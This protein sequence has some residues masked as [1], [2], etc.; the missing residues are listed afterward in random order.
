V[1]VES[2]LKCIEDV[3]RA[4]ILDAGTD[5]LDF[6]EISKQVLAD[7]EALHKSGG[8]DAL[9][10]RELVEAVA[11]INDT[12]F[13]NGYLDIVQE[14]KFSKAF[15]DKI[16][17]LPPMEK[18][19]RL[20]Q[21][22]RNVA[23][24]TEKV[25]AADIRI[26]ALRETAEEKAFAKLGMAFDKA[27]SKIGVGGL[28]NNAEFG[29]LALRAML[30]GT[31]DASSKLAP[32][33]EIVGATARGLN[34]DAI[35]A[36]KQA[37][38]P[39]RFLKGY[40]QRKYSVGALEA[41]KDRAVSL[42]A[43]KL[44]PVRHTPGI[45][46]TMQQVAERAYRSIL[47]G[48][49]STDTISGNKSFV[50]QRKVHFKDPD[51]EVDFFLEFGEKPPMEILMD[52]V[53]SSAV[54]SATQVRY[55][56]RWAQLMRKQTEGAVAEAEA[57]FRAGTLLSGEKNKVVAMGKR[58][59]ADIDFNLGALNKFDNPTVENFTN[60]LM[61]YQSARLLGTVIKYTTF[62][63]HIS[64]VQRMAE[65]GSLNIV[66]GYTETMTEFAKNVKNNLRK[67]KDADREELNVLL[68]IHDVTFQASVFRE[69]A[70]EGAA[71]NARFK[72]AAQFTQRAAQGVLKVQGAFMAAR[73]VQSST[74][75]QT[76]RTMTRRAGDTF[77]QLSRSAPI[78][79]N[80]L[81]E[82]G[83]KA[84]VW[85]KFRKSDMN[86]DFGIVDLVKLEAKDERAAT[87][88]A[89]FL[90]EEGRTAMSIPDS[91]ARRFA[92]G[93]GI[94]SDR[95]GNA[96]AAAWRLAMQFQSTPFTFLRR[97]MARSI[98]EASTIGGRHRFTSVVYGAGGLWLYGNAIVQLERILNDKPTYDLF[99]P[100][101]WS[102]G[103]DK[104]GLMWHLG[105]ALNQGV[106][107]GLTD[108]TRPWSDVAAGMAGPTYNLLF[109]VP[110]QV[111][112]LASTPYTKDDVRHTMEFGASL[113]PGQNL[114]GAYQ[115][116]HYLIDTQAPKSRRARMAE[117]RRNKK[118]GISQ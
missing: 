56:P 62:D 14:L 101:L 47:N 85:D 6:S 69:Q 44:D 70:I 95:L 81:S 98:R 49:G 22:N 24:L 29:E 99:S 13:I 112:R 50:K 107:R 78:L 114:P 25:R 11:T 45:G 64:T 71:S 106:R 16:K 79:H 51:S 89:T 28:R 66:S 10:E 109:E 53:R 92:K 43:D 1:S 110:G 34:E 19:K 9:T 39:V 94:A 68:G 90:R 72:N 65:R 48:K 57:Q 36:M 38:I 102:G 3:H 21:T 63:L 82:V 17:D 93:S 52:T 15:V 75:Q 100:A 20:Q 113:I 37:G 4:A 7:I 84:D 76:L 117:R 12:A 30:E 80:R 46:E 5:A 32:A 116:L 86:D 55:G 41:K 96:P 54:E 111:N 74:A 60:T 35:G 77:D 58:V 8:L 88:I 18:L 103:L 59:G 105:Y 97:S 23:T 2:I 27:S 26:D 40:M 118:L 104:S 67:V 33:A 91:Y 42:L 31:V 73:A 87:D 83:I 115:V 61:F 108:D